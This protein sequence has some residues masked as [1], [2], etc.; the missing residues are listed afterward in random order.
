MLTLLCG[1]AHSTW[2]GWTWPAVGHGRAVAGAYAGDRKLEGRHSTSPAPS[3]WSGAASARL[4]TSSRGRR[5]RRCRIMTW[6]AWVDAPTTSASSPTCRGLHPGRRS[7]H[8]RD[9]AYQKATTTAASSSRS[10]TSGSRTAS[11][12]AGPRDAGR[13]C[14]A[15][16]AQR[17]GDRALEAQ[18]L[19]G[20]AEIRVIRGEPELAIRDADGRWR[21]PELQNAALETRT[22]ESSP[23][24]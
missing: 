18:A 14:G 19:A 2:A 13:R 23:W 7:V 1:I 10:T 5:K 22:C 8:P 15:G 16:K 6:P 17:L 4:P 3:R 21:A 9:R 24:R 12:A 11:R 20:R